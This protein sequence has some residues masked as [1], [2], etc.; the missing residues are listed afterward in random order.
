MGYRTYFEGFLTLTPKLT[1]EQKTYL[2]DFSSSVRVK[3]DAK[4][5]E[6]K[7]DE[8]RSAVGLPIGK[9]GGYCVYSAKDGYNGLVY[10]ETVLSRFDPPEGQP[11]RWCQWNTNEEGDKILWD[12]AEKFYDHEEWIHYINDNFLKP[13]GIVANGIITWQGEVKV[14]KGKIIAKEGVISIL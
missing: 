11:G 14:D 3:R 10:D 6:S 4:L 8:V 9:E 12:G 2:N 1:V 13:W 5:C 7:V